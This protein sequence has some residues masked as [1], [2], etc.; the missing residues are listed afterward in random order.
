MIDPVTI[1]LIEALLAATTGRGRA[2]VDNDD[3]DTECAMDEPSSSS[4]LIVE[5]LSF[6]PIISSSFSI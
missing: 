4:S 5:T 2:E 1:R 3:V 6:D